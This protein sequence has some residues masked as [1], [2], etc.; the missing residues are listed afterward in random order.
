[1]MMPLRPVDYIDGYAVYEVA[2]HKTRA[3]VY[4]MSWRNDAIR[5]REPA[6]VMRGCCACDDW[7]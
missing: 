2:E 7:R 3:V 1:M 5:Q 4:A 6:L